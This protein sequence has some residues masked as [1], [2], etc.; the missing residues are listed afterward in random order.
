MFLPGLQADDIV[1][2][3]YSIY[4]AS[5]AYLGMDI[6]FTQG[7]GIVQSA[8]LAFAWPCS[9]FVAWAAVQYAEFVIWDKHG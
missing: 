1:W 3:G 2:I 8:K 4:P 7:R 6:N 9:I 5:D